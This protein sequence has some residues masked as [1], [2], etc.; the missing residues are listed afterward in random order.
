MKKTIQIPNPF[1]WIYWLFKKHKCSFTKL[2]ADI[3]MENC[4]NYLVTQCKCGKVSVN[5]VHRESVAYLETTKR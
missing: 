4:T 2:V 3:A 5:R 1:Y